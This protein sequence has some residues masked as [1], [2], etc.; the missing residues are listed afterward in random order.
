MDVRFC[1][2]RNHRREAHMRA[3]NSAI[4]VLRAPPK[5]ASGELRSLLKIDLHRGSATR[6][7]T[8]RREEEFRFLRCQ[9]CYSPCIRCS[10]YFSDPFGYHTI[11][12][13]NVFASISL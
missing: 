3:V 13:S 8:V 9:R 11:S 1:E 10:V 12:K 6:K 7:L 2:H 5:R 4:C